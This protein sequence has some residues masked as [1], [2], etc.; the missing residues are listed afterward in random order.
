MDSW[1]HCFFWSQ[2]HYTMFKRVSYPYKHNCLAILLDTV[3]LQNGQT[4]SCK[5]PDMH[6][7]P[8]YSLSMWVKSAD[9]SVARTLVELQPSFKVMTEAV[10]RMLAFSNTDEASRQ[11]T[12]IQMKNAYWHYILI[13]HNGTTVEIVMDMDKPAT[14]ATLTAPPSYQVRKST[15]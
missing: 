15:N 3:S 10:S 13:C 4:I 9:F 5:P 6:A 14:M 7:V 11:A 1:S 8:Q 2:S 12:T